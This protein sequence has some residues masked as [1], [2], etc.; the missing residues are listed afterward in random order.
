M[1]TTNVREYEIDLCLPERYRWSE[2][3]LK[4]QASTRRL[5]KA[6]LQDL[7]DVTWLHRSP[8]LNGIFALA[9]RVYG[10]L[11]YREIKSWARAMGVSTATATFLNCT[12]ELCSLGEHMG[13]KI[14]R[15][16]GCTSGI[17]YVPG[18][19]MVHVRSMDWPI[20][21]IGKATRIFRFNENGR[22]FVSIGAT[23]MV[24]VIQGMVPGGYSVTINWAPTNEEPGFAYGPSFL[25]REVLSECNTYSQAVK[26]LCNAPLAAPVF[27]SV[28][29]VEKGE[30]CIVERSRY[31]YA[32]R[33]YTGRPLVQANHY[34]TPEFQELNA[35]IKEE[36]EDGS[37]IEDSKW[38][39]STLFS[40]MDRKLEGLEDAWSCLNPHPVTNDESYQQMMFCPATGEYQ[41]WRWI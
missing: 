18:K 19:G 28:C 3:V 13:A 38:R 9:Y 26:A 36:D 17:K 16:F 11:Y 6:G 7:D 12:Y 23:G 25:L 41:A 40:E 2:V 1:Y 33:E 10:G 27:F 31:E 8:V 24:N 20:A 15:P 29:G 22:Q 34:V 39:A 4:E 14:M 21:E 35:P 5:T 30:A 37:V 32:V